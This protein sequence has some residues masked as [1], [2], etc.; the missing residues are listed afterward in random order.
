MYKRQGFG[1]ILPGAQAFVVDE[2]HQLPELAAQFFGE[3]LGARPLVEL[4]RDAIAECKDVPGAL[5]SVQE[6]AR[7]L[8]Q[9]CLLYTS[10]C[11]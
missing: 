7:A 2:A 10:R 11:V 1:E 9:A 3:G 5:G 8:E 4:A 6:P